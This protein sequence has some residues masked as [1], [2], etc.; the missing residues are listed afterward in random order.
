M[1]STWPSSAVWRNPA[2]WPSAFPRLRWNPIGS[3]WSAA[4]YCSATLRTAVVALW[5]PWS[6]WWI[7]FV[8]GGAFALGTAWI[9]WVIPPDRCTHAVALVRKQYESAFDNSLTRLASEI[10]DPRGALERVPPGFL[11]PEGAIPRAKQVLDAGRTTLPRGRAAKVQMLIGRGLLPELGPRVFVLRVTNE[12]HAF[13]RPD[14]RRI[15]EELEKKR[16]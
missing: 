6:R 2:R 7:L 8:L 12:I 15:Q 10:S 16:S 5:V 4:L 9:L 1:T 13:L 11:D 14:V 3:R